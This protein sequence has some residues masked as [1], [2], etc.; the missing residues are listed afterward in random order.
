MKFRN[1]LCLAG[2]A[3]LAQLGQAASLK[4]TV[5]DADGVG[6]EDAVV[7]VTPA[8]GNAQNVAASAPLIIKQEK[9]QFVPKVTLATPGSK[10][11]FLNSDPWDHHIHAS[12]G[13]QFGVDYVTLFQARQNAAVEGKGSIPY[14]V[15]VDKAGVVLLGCHLHSSMTGYVYVAASPWTIKTGADG[16]A[17]LD[18]LPPGEAKLTLWQANEIRTI[19][20]M[21]VTLN[22]RQT[23][24]NHQLSV[25]V[26]KRKA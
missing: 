5:L 9:N 21:N 16:V 19:P 13:N 12:T 24:I 10:L 2:W 8:S 11:R 22:Q 14:D 20:V 26:R 18:D 1:I 17:V 25:R 15:T 4:V 6:V 7:S 23:V 3:M